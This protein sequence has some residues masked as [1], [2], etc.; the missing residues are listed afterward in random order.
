MVGNGRTRKTKRVSSFVIKMEI[1]NDLYCACREDLREEERIAK[2]QRL[3]AERIAEH[4]KFVEK[5]ENAKKQEAEILKWEKLNSIKKTEYIKETAGKK[6]REGMLKYK[7]DLDK[8]IAEK[9]ESLKQEKLENELYAKADREKARASDRKFFE[10]ADHV[11]DMLKSRGG[12]TTIPLEKVVEVRIIIIRFF[13]VQFEIFFRN[14][15]KY[16][17]YHTKK[18]VRVMKWLRNIEIIQDKWPTIGN[19]IQIIIKRIAIHYM[20]KVK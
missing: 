13:I 14:I 7:E 16:I 4:V 2:I 12:R 11:R 3:K 10:Y 5:Q 9:M 17:I 19:P 1:T 18:H 15:K 20:L 8:Q 6:K